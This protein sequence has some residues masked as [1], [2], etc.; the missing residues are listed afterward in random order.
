[1]NLSRF[2]RPTGPKRPW[3]AGVLA[4]AVTGLGHA[5]LRRWLRGFGWLAVTYAAALLLVPPEAIEALA[6]GDPSAD[7]TQVLPPLIVIVAS[8]VDAY[9]LARRT[10][11]NAVHVSA[12]EFEE[13]AAGGE[14]A[15]QPACPSCGRELDADLDFCPWCSTELDRPG[16]NGPGGDG[17]G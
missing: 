15:E 10:R 1:M 7:P 4:L 6:A 9:V 14:A 13:A 2:T 16:P 8:A 3:L 11:S 17:G 12:A 5:Y